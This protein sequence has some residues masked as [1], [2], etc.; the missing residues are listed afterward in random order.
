LSSDP[1]RH[2]GGSVATVRVSRAGQVTG[3]DPNEKWYPGPPVRGLRH[4]AD[5]L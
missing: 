1:D 4:E 3:D 2:T 5:H